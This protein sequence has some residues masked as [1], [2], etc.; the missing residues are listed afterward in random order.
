MQT[1]IV[2]MLISVSEN[3]QFHDTAAS[4]RYMR[5]L[6]Q[7]TQTLSP[8]SRRLPRTAFRAIFQ[9]SLHQ[10]FLHLSWLVPIT[11]TLHGTPGLFI[12]ALLLYGL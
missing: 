2:I 12:G 10:F 11:A 6:I 4:A 3:D 8:C 5:N 7:V 9:C 1:S